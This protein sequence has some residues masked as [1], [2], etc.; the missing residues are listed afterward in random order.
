MKRAACGNCCG[1]SAAGVTAQAQQRSVNFNWSN[2]MAPG[3]L[4]EFTA[5]ETSAT[6]GKSGY[7]VGATA[8][9]LQRQIAASSRSWISR[10]FTLPTRPE[11]TK[12]LAIYDPGNVFA[13]TICGALR[14]R[15]QRQEGSANL[16]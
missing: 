6:G 13:A 8:Y 7:D 2:Y 10:R 11:V 15:L 4:E 9:F 5:L 1:C 14:H 3:V 12:R 16:A